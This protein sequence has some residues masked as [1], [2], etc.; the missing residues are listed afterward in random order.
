MLV[1]LLWQLVP[2]SLPYIT[3]GR[4]IATRSDGCSNT[5]FGKHHFRISALQLDHLGATN[6]RDTQFLI[7]I[8]ILDLAWLRKVC[9]TIMVYL[10]ITLT[11][12][13]R[14]TL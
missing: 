8:S 4:G 3:K 11:R 2:H 14:Q 12:P 5:Y 6:E 1:H 7:T 10:Y 13:K 9:Y